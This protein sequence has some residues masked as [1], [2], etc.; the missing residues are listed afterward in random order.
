MTKEEMEKW[1]RE[2]EKRKIGNSEERNPSLD[3]DALRDAGS[4]IGEE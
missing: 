3:E 4:N 1:H 2:M